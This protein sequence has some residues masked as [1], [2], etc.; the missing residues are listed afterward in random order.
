MLEQIITA[1]VLIVSILLIRVLLRGRLS[2]RVRYALWLLVAL[3]LLIPGSLFQVNQTPVQQVEQAVESVRYTTVKNHFY[4]KYDKNSTETRAEQAEQYDD[5]DWVEDAVGGP[6]VI[7]GTAD[8]ETKDE[9][10][11]DV[12]V[13]KDMLQPLRAIWYLGMAFMALWFIGTNLAFGLRLRKTAKRTE[14]QAA[15]PVYTAQIP[16]PCLWGRRI[17]VTPSCLEDETRLRHVLAHEEAHLRHGDRLWS[18]VRCLCL[19]VWWFHPLVWVAASLS[20]KDCELAADEGAVK[21]L[22]EGERLAYGRTLLDIVAQRT[23][24]GSLLQTAT[25]MHAG[26]KSLKKRIVQIANNKKMKWYV[27]VLAILLAVLAAACAFTGARE[28]HGTPFDLSADLEGVDLEQE[29]VV[30][31]YFPRGLSDYHKEGRFAALDEIQ[32]EFYSPSPDTDVFPELGYWRETDGVLHFRLSE[33][34]G[35]IVTG[36]DVPKEELVK[37]VESF[38][39]VQGP[40]PALDADS[41]E[42]HPWGVD[43]LVLESTAAGF[44]ISFQGTEPV[45][46]LDVLEYYW[47]TYW[48]SNGGR[49]IELA[50]Q[51]WLEVRQETDLDGKPVWYLTWEDL[52]DL[53]EKKNWSIGIQV[54]NPAVKETKTFYVESMTMSAPSD[55]WGISFETWNATPLGCVACVRQVADDE[56]PHIR[57]DGRYLLEREENG[58]WITME[59]QRWTNTPLQINRDTAVSWSLVWED[60]YGALPDGNYRLAVQVR[61]MDTEEIRTYYSEFSVSEEQWGNT[62]NY[63]RALREIDP[64]GAGYLL[65]LSMPEHGYTDTLP[66]AE[67]GLLDRFAYLMKWYLWTPWDRAEADGENRMT[68]TLS[69]FSG[70]RTM[71]FVDH[72]VFCGLQI[73]N[74]GEVQWWK[75]LPL[76]S[77]YSDGHLVGNLRLEY[78]A[79][80]ASYEQITFRETG[81]AEDAARYF[82]ETAYGEHLMNQAPGSSCG[83]TDYELLQWDCRQ[84][85]ADGT[86]VLGWFE[87]KLTPE[88]GAYSNLW[89]G[90]SRPV[91]EGNFDGPLTMSREFVLQKQSDGLWRCVQFGTGGCSLQE[92]TN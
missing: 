77:L 42:R 40:E 6:Y 16:S 74:G 25:T 84:V 88:T 1:S 60:V 86:A 45:P 30:P 37:L 10:R 79:L 49:A 17:Y 44:V 26:A 80:A 57:I 36:G 31:G 32:I 24:P 67:Q 87:A 58:Q 83:A 29:T 46:E 59:P 91:E 15:R 85:S 65:R 64:D 48:S 41:E 66:V 55:D 20:R 75:G 28:I 38:Y 43:L 8:A 14:V 21:S 71:A 63:D 9:Y 82:A 19:I 23:A 76:E 27:L 13:R 69:D 5:L 33:D 7:V 12:A 68:L 81:G 18:L 61:N 92:E 47:P 90:N 54:Y 3:R 11:I 2:A 50:P 51:R 4:A 72:G 89:A 62:L 22:G 52:G 56:N 78:D 35:C 73:K 39:V 53:T 34:W 70:E